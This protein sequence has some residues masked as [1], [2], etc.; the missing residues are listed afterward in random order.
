MRLGASISALTGR[1]GV[2]ERLGACVGMAETRSGKRR[3][4]K[5]R[6]SSGEEQWVTRE[7]L[8]RLQ[9]QRA[10]RFRRRRQQRLLLAALGTLALALAVL[11]L[12]AGARDGQGAAVPASPTAGDEAAEAPAAAA[13]E[14]PAEPVIEPAVEAVEP[15]VERTVR[16]WAGAWSR[17]DVAA[18]LGFYSP[19]FRPADGLPRTAWERLRR[20]RLVGPAWIRVDLDGLEVAVG[21]GGVAEARFRQTYRSPDYSDSVFKILR[22]VEEDGRWRIVSEGVA[23]G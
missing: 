22:L 18:Y 2:A 11:F 20:R 9:E 8:W 17:Q 21:D 1:R 16:A 14:P 7:E 10:E 5:V 23:P 19:R 12:V 15:A 6:R 3:L 4:Y 13:V